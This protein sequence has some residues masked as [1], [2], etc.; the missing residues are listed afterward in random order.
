MLSLSKNFQGVLHWK[1][2]LID[3]S[4]PNGSLEFAV[5]AANSSGFFPVRVSFRTNHTY[6]AMQVVAVTDE[7]DQGVDFT[8]DSGLSVEQYDIE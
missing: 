2:P 8:S 4:S 1:I 5:G 6:C 7:N 3:S